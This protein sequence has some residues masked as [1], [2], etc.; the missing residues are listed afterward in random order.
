M[1]MQI[2]TTLA[3]NTNVSLAAE[4]PANTDR[5]YRFSCPG[6]RLRDGVLLRVRQDRG[7]EWVGLFSP[8]QTKFS[9]SASCLDGRLLVVVSEGAAYLVNV[10]QPAAFAC[11]DSKFVIGM[12][13]VPSAGV[14]VLFDYSD[15]WG[16]GADG[17]LWHTETDADGI[18]IGRNQKE[19]NIISGSLD[20]P[21]KGATAFS[22]DALSGELKL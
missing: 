10:E 6:M 13:V 21:G 3:P 17:I 12:H 8:G 14:V 18:Y 22:I 7:F 11:L 9:A 16:I 2:D 1:N 20:I 4:R 15:L 5:E 19:I